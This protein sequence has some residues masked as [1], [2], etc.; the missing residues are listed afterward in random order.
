VFFLQVEIK[1]SIPRENMDLIRGPK[2]KKLFVGGLPS[3]VAD[4]KHLICFLVLNSNKK[5]VVLWV[6]FLTV[7]E[8]EQSVNLFNGFSF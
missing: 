2:T 1:R 5:Q 3:S 6:N 8:V 7:P 4:G